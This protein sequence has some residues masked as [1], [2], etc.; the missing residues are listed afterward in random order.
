MQRVVGRVD[1][2]NFIE[3][4]VRIW[5]DRFHIRFHVDGWARTAFGLAG[6]GFEIGRVGRCGCE[7]GHQ[8]EE[9]FGRFGSDGLPMLALG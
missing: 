3:D 9:S 6:S 4:F 7:M 5:V 2:R 1:M 8:A